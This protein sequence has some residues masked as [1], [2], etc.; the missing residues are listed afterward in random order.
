VQ[1]IGI[2]HD[3]HR[4]LAGVLHGMLYLV[5]DIRLSGKQP[6]FEVL[7]AMVYYIHAFPERFHHP[8]EDAYLFRFLALRYPD[9]APLIDQLKTEHRTGAEKIRVLEQAL[10]RYRCG[11][12][13][14]F[15]AFADAVQAYAAFHWD[16]MRAEEDKLIPLAREHLTAEDWK[17]IDAA[18]T[19]HSDPLFGVAAESEYNNLFRKIVNLAPPPIGVGP[20]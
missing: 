18:F 6:K 4:S 8:K 14:E 1:A 10:E 9:A 16:H 2:I 19:G 3:E 12:A 13:A 17:E 5:R 15:P 11:G 20:A 7:D